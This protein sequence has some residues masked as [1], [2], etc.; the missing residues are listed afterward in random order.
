M[1]TTA[2]S[3]AGRT[4]DLPTGL[5]RLRARLKDYFPTEAAA[6]DGYLAAVQSA[7]KASGLYFAEKAIPRPAARLAGRLMRAP[8]L[9]WASQTTLDVLHR[10]THNRRADRRPHRP[11]GRLRPT[12]GAK[13]LRHSR[14]RRRALF[15]RRQLP[16]GRRIAHRRNHRPHDR[17]QRRD[18]SSSAPMSQQI[19]VQNGKATGVTNGRRPR[20]PRRSGHQRCRRAQHLRATG[21]PTAAHSRRSPPR[22][23]LAC[24][25]EPLHGRQ[26]NRARSLG[27][28]GTNL[29]I[30]PSQLD[31][32]ANLARFVVDPSA[33]FPVVYISFPSAKDP[34][35]ERQHPGRAT[36]EAV[37]FAP[38]E[39]FAPWEDSRWK[40]RDDDYDAFKQT[41]AA[42]PPARSRARTFPQSRAKSTTPSFPRRSPRATS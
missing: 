15:Q 39:W 13:Q 18:T 3:S 36:L 38:Y 31:H 17:T 5:E 37:V 24:S 21:P 40:R 8:F 2:S 41:L 1:F 25:P 10:F 30:Y 11:M 4:F 42:A 29:W 12:A 22:S 19:I 26:A 16:G 20:I 7:Q 28:D 34:D 14:H 6:I 33:P 32:D 27:L 35:F 23:R 9:R